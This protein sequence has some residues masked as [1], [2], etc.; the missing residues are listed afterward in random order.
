[1]VT[2]SVFVLIPLIL[3]LSSYGAIARAVL[4]MRST[5]GLQKVFGSCG[6]HLL[7]VSLFLI[8]GMFIYLQ[9]PSGGSQDQGEF[10][11]LFYTVVPPSL[12]PLIYT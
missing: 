8:P 2:S 6:A 5:A 10:I 3:I 9:P 1:M 7:V 4:R 11:A 12:N